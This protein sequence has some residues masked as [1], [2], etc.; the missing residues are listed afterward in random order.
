MVPNDSYQ[1]DR[2]KVPVDKAFS[3]GWFLYHPVVIG[4]LHITSG[5]DVDAA[6]DFY[7]GFLDE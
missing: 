4:R 3:I 2:S 1:G 5:E 7:T 6:L